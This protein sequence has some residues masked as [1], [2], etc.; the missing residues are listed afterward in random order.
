MTICITDNKCTRHH[1]HPSKFNLACW[2][3]VWHVWLSIWKCLPESALMSSTHSSILHTIAHN[4]TSK[5]LNALEMSSPINKFSP[6]PWQSEGVWSPPS[7]VDEDA[8]C[9]NQLEPRNHRLQKQKCIQVLKQ[10]TK[11]SSSRVTVQTFGALMWP[12]PSPASPWPRNHWWHR[13]K[14][15]R[16]ERRW[17]EYWSGA[18]RLRV[19]NRWISALW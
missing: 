17:G 18:E 3:P 14:A 13:R 9:W 10:N 12:I 4:Q 16:L 1:R 2:P 11:V 5:T 7:F 6:W 8:P 15:T 19:G